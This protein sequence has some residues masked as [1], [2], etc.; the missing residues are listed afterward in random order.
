[1][2]I[3]ENLPTAVNDEAEPRPRKCS[4]GIDCD[5]KN[6][7]EGSSNDGSGRRR[8]SVRSVSIL[9]TAGPTR[10][11]AAVLIQEAATV[12]WATTLAVQKQDLMLAPPAMVTPVG[13]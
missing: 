3:C 7:G 1:M 6:A 11:T 12:L 5:P 4:G 9:T 8:V 10:F 2:S 13:C